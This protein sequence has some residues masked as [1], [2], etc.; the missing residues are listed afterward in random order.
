MNQRKFETRGRPRWTTASP[1]PLRAS[2]S[3]RALSIGFE[4]YRPRAR[5][6]LTAQDLHKSGLAEAV[7]P[8]QLIAI[9]AA[10]LHGDV[11]ERGVAPNC[12]AMLEA[13]ITR[14]PEIKKP[15]VA[16]WVRLT[17]RAHYSSVVPRIPYP[18]N[19]E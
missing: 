19:G 3:G 4:R 6:Q 9:P 7:R 13:T 1:P 14:V 12:V 18:Y 2:A 16:S 17:A 5:L 8:D 10:E 11:Q 15:A